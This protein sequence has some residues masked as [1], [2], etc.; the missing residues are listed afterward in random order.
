MIAIVERQRDREA[1]EKLLALGYQLVY[2][3]LDFDI[4]LRPPYSWS[5]RP[6]WG[7]SGCE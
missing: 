4:L 3:N 5:A 2:E 1:T 7:S 6:G